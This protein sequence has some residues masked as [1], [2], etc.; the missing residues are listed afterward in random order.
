[1]QKT[2]VDVEDCGSRERE[3]AIVEKEETKLEGS[4]TSISIARATVGKQRQVEDGGATRVGRRTNHE[5]HGEKELDREEDAGDESRKDKGMRTRRSKADGWREE[6]G[7]GVVEGAG[8]KTRR[9][10]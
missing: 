5:S 1:M 4:K 9:G 7:V 8:E 6:M 3:K 10:R 2:R